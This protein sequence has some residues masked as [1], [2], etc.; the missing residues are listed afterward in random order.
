MPPLPSLANQRD[1]LLALARTLVECES[2]SRDK[3]R[4]DALADL[5]GS[6]LAPL[7]KLERFAN[8]LGGDHLCLR[9][10]APHAPTDAR[11]ALLLCHYD[12]VWPAG[13]LTTRPL[14]IEGDTVFGP[15][16]Y[17]MKASIA[18]AILALRA[19]HN[20]E[21]QLPRPI[22]LLITSDE[23]IGSLTS[24]DLIEAEARQAAH[25]LVLEP[26]IEEGHLLKTA[27]KGV[28]IY[29]LSISGR[30]AHAGVE[31]EKG[32]NALIEL[33]HQMLAISSLA[34]PS[35]GTSVSV[36]YGTG[37]S[38]SFNI[39]PDSANCVVDVRVWSASEAA[40]LEA[41]FANVQPVLPGAT[42]SVGGGFNRP[43]MEA[44]P[45]SRELCARA[46]AL[47][48]E[49]GLSLGA[50]A[51]G[52]ASDGNFTAAM[53]IATLDGLGAP[54]LGAHALHEQ[55]DLPA[56]MV[57]ADLLLALISRI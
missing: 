29:T 16:I 53:G 57:R 52:G 28:G 1:E 7:G 32:I 49:L 43:P 18:M 13:I 24:R 4:C 11:P 40:R 9:L 46:Q 26:P 36:S 54:G 3:V 12:T 20:L 17:D 27:R 14:R 30:A 42:L 5:L 15:G 39:I 25:V 23:E 6:L 34:D 22:H 10:P 48:S 47:G 41:A 33:A 51:T 45:A 21:L 31:P 50:G 38:N 44:I 35:Q 55:I 37:G 56:T 19:V 8:P 2:P